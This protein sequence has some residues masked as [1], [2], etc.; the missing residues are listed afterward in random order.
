[1]ITSATNYS[2]ASPRDD[3]LFSFEELNSFRDPYIECLQSTRCLELLYGSSAIDI[4]SKLLIRDS[5]QTHVQN[6]LHFYSLLEDLEWRSNDR[7]VF[8]SIT[9]A[10]CCCKIINSQE[11]NDF[12]NK[13][14]SISI[15]LV[16]MNPHL[17]NLATEFKEDIFRQ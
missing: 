4:H 9:Q 2:T 16:P 8:N 3:N 5:L 12:L 7:D 13:R 1:M 15:G 10:I 14:L 6:S 11:M 17:M